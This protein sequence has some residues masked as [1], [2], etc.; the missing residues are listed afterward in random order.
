MVGRSFVVRRMSIRSE[1]GDRRRS[2]VA[3]QAMMLRK[4]IANLLVFVVE[5]GRKQGVASH[6][7]KYPH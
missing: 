7:G 6:L 1:K 4:Q 3:M 5:G 2:E